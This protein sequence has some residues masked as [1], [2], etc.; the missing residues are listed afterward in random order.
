M[1]DELDFAIEFLGDGGESGSEAILGEDLLVARQQVQ[2]P[3]RSGALVT[4]MRSRRE[5][6][7]ARD[8]LRIVKAVCV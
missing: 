2:W 4:Y 1:G 3:H 8:Q 5:T 6:M 7:L